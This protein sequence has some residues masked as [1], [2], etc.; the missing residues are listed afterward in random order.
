MY[1]LYN[2][3]LIILKDCRFQSCFSGTM[4]DA[5]RGLVGAIEKLYR[6]GKCTDI[7][8]VCQ[9]SRKPAHTAVLIARYIVLFPHARFC[10]SAP[11]GH[12]DLTGHV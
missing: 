5:Q 12:S 8:L 11:M 2:I 1:F 4:T 9:G 6:E 3:E 7:T 10:K